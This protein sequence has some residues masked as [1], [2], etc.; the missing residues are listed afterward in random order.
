LK[1]ELPVLDSDVMSA[2]YSLPFE[3]R[4]NG[5]L[6]KSIM[7]KTYPELMKIRS[8]RSIFPLFSPWWIHEGFKRIRDNIDFIKNDFKLWAGK[9]RYNRTG[10]CDR[11][12]HFKYTLGGYVKEAISELDLKLIDHDS[13]KQ[14]LENHFSEQKDYSSDIAKLL[15]IKI[16]MEKNFP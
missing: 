3:Q 11:G 12:F 14:L 1:Y 10:M 4:I 8:T 16:W 9:P 2:V 5:R 6:V 15:T 7:K 13:I